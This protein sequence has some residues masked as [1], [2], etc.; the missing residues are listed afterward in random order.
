[1]SQQDHSPITTPIKRKRRN[2]WQWFKSLSLFKKIATIGAA[3]LAFMIALPL[4]V[5]VADPEGFAEAQERTAQERE[6]REAERDAEE[7]AERLA[8]EEAEAESERLAEEEAEAEQV[9]QEEA[10]R[11]AEEE[12]QRQEEEEAAE[13]EQAAIEEAE[14]AE[15]EVNMTL[16]DHLER[17][18][19]LDV[20]SD[21]EAYF[22]EGDES[23][24][25]DS[26]QVSDEVEIGLT[27]NM[28][29]NDARRA[30]IEGL[31]YVR[32]NITDD[33]DELFFSFH[34]R[35]NADAT[36]NQPIIG[37]A[38]AVYDRETVESIDSD[39]VD[40]FNVWEARD[41]GA[42]SEECS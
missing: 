12:R 26:I 5:M 35:G 25:V 10:E 11:E 19:D 14:A 29:C 7:E 8:E 17:L 13:A 37:L 6:E 1:M 33:Y 16:G 20:F 38:S 30:T 21:A 31:E 32:D 22:A 36:G 41:D 9:A 42:I 15:A 34:V 23:Y 18:A 27:V 4:I 24:P 40:V 2:P 28:T 39:H 3:V